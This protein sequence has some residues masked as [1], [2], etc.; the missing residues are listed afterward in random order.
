[1]EGLFDRLG[2]RTEWILVVEDELIL[3]T[4]ISKNILKAHK[5][6]SSLPA[7]PHQRDPLS[8]RD[9]RLKAV[10]AA[11]PRETRARQE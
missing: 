11:R 1:M 9:P 6:R 3:Q 2:H 4:S 7:V 10:N 8:A 5:V